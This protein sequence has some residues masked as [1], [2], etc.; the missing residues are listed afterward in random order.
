MHCAAP[1]L[2]LPEVTELHW[3]LCCSITTRSKPVL[4]YPTVRLILPLKTLTHLNT[5]E[6]LAGGP[7]PISGLP[8]LPV[9]ELMKNKLVENQTFWEIEETYDF[10][11]H[12]VVTSNNL[13]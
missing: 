3:N 1:T 6:D 5:T 12:F 4:P 7:V 2:P 11:R 8:S 10:A 13:Q 9:Y